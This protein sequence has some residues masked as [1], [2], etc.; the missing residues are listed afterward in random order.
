MPFSIDFVAFRLI[1]SFQ[2]YF[3]GLILIYRTFNSLYLN[4]ISTIKYSTALLVRS[5]ANIQESLVNSFL[6]RLQMLL[7]ILRF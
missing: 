3:I 2:N 5:L 7:T 1:E 4:Q 6:D